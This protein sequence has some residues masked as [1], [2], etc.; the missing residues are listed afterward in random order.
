MQRAHSLRA[1]H[2]H[3]RQHPPLPRLIITPPSPHPLLLIS[4]H[5]I[6]HL[7]PSHLTSSHPPR[8]SSPHS[9]ALVA[10]SLVDAH[11]GLFEWAKTEIEKVVHDVRVAGVRD[12]IAA[13]A[14]GFISL[15][16]SYD[17]VVKL[18]GGRQPSESGP[19]NKAG[20][21]GSTLASSSDKTSSYITDV[22]EAM[23]Q[24]DII[25]QRLWIEVAGCDA[26][27]SGGLGLKAMAKIAVSHLTP[28][29]VKLVF[30]DLFTR[31]ALAAHRMRTRRLVDSTSGEQSLPLVNFTALAAETVRIIQDPLIAKQA[32]KADVDAR[33]AEIDAARAAQVAK[34][35]EKRPLLAAAPVSASAVAATPTAGVAGSKRKGRVSIASASAASPS[36]ASGLTVIAA[37]AP[38]PAPPPSLLPA[39]PETAA[40]ADTGWSTPTW[41]VGSIVSVSKK[42]AGSGSAVQHFNFECARLGLTEFP[43][44][45]QSLTGACRGAAGGCRTCANQTTLAGGPTA[46]P[47]GLVARIKRSADPDT[48]KRIV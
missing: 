4:S 46:V 15:D 11:D 37:A 32:A 1:E 21:W 6:R 35:G 10:S 40:A 22:P 20:A 18:L 39:A 23:D 26:T 14:I 31:L 17:A 24:A 27:P 25:L 43:C 42:V 16:I 7:T 8:P 3:S 45:I 44:A 41:A 29:N 2:S 5:P 33:L 48:A 38:A 19:V 12:E 36:A 30:E 13:L 28:E 9:P 34:A 47:V